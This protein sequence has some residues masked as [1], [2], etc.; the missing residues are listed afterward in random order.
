LTYISE[1]ISQK[2]LYGK[3]LDEL[4]LASSVVASLATGAPDS[5]YSK[6][7]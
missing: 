4:T 7:C 6:T 5:E 2:T 1:R 3:K